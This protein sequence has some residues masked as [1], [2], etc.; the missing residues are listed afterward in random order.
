MIVLLAAVLA[1]AAFLLLVRVFWAKA[2]PSRSSVLL[3]TAAIVLV[4]GLGVLAATGRLHWL[5]AAGAAVFPFL[6][7]AFSLLRFWPLLRRF[8]PLAGQAFAGRQAH[9][10]DAGAGPEQSEVETR[11]LR[12]TLHH[13]SGRMDGEVLTGAFEGRKLSTLEPDELR[14]LRAA[15]SDADSVRLLDSYIE[16]HHPGWDDATGGARDATA[17]DG[18]MTESRALEV[19]GLEAG[20]T[21]E[22]VIEAHRRLIQKLHPDR[23]GSTYL[24]AT[25]NEAKRVLLGS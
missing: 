3:T 15:L 10:A 5:V 12:M 20:A 8:A 18:E 23:G 11:D 25:L 4:A 1:G 7:R 14:A 24:A 21:K 19:L 16:R 2:Q 6:R 17:S 9:A 22:E 13:G